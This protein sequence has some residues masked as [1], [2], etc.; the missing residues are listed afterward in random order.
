LALLAHKLSER[1]RELDPLEFVLPLT[2]FAAGSVDI[3]S[4]AKLGGIF[5]SAM[6]GNLAFMA[7]YCSAGA[8]YSAIGSLIALLGFSLGACAG[9]LLTR[10]RPAPSAVTTLL[11]TETIFLSAVVL[12]WFCASHRNGRPSTDVLILILSSAMGLQSICGKK[13]NL[14]N[15]PTVV[16]TSTLTNI[17][18]AVTEILARGKTG[19]PADTKRQ[20]IAFCMYFIGAFTA[21]LFSFGNFSII[22]VLPLTAAAVALGIHMSKTVQ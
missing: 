1:A 10:D 2:S 22:I 14:S 18:I 21:G 3:I 17:V 5:A 12:L 15:I 20:I 4:F 6:T 9:T 7:L 19:L 13:I 8:I 16:F 11:I